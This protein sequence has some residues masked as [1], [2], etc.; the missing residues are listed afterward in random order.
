MLLFVVRFASRYPSSAAFDASELE[1]MFWS[2]VSR[3]TCAFLVVRYLCKGCMSPQSLWYYDFDS[4]ETIFWSKARLIA[5]CVCCCRNTC[6][7]T[8]CKKTMRNG[9]HC[10]TYISWGLLLFIICIWHATDLQSSVLFIIYLSAALMVWLNDFN[11]IWFADDLMKS[12]SM[13]TAKL[14]AQLLPLLCLQFMQ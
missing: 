5:A 12:M 2:K 1:A 10:C 3:L 13:S 14:W 9:F 7:S 11:L 8:H 6:R 4:S